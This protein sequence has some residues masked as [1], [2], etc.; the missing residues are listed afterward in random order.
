MIQRRAAGR[1]Q[2]SFGWARSPVIDDD[3]L[4]GAGVL[5]EILQHVAVCCLRQN[6]KIRVAPLPLSEAT[7]EFRLDPMASARTLSGPRRENA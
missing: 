5:L 3:Q 2:Q 6:V 1:C 7:I 4:D